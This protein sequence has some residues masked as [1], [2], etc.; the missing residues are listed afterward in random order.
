MSFST[1]TFENL[2]IPFD[3]DGVEVVLRVVTSSGGTV[4]VSFTTSSG[5]PRPIPNDILVTAVFIPVN[6]TIPPRLLNVYIID[7]NQFG[8]KVT[9]RNRVLLVREQ[10]RPSLKRLL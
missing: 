6:F 4:Q 2:N 1:S 7:N 9:H 8:Y 5:V 10:F 3:V